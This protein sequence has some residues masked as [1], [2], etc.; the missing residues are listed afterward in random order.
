MS[1]TVSCGVFSGDKRQL[2]KGYAGVWSGTGELRNDT[3][4]VDPVILVQASAATLAAC[5]YMKITEFNRAYFITDVVSKTSALCEIHGHC[6]VLS[7]YASAIKKNQGIV[8]RTSATSLQNHYLNDP[9]LPVSSKRSVKNLA[10][11]KAFDATAESI[12]LV[13]AG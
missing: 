11:P 3:S 4:V 7:T 8:G 2:T 13:T 5:N 6:D 1:F 12:I 10:F 9:L